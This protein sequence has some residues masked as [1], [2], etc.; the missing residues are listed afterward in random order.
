VV[1]EVV[2]IQVQQTIS[3]RIKAKTGIAVD[4]LNH[5]SGIAICFCHSNTL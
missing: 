2:S 5:Y 3:G 1:F 4:T